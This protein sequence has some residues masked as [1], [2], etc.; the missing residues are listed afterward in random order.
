M[1]KLLS[2]LLAF[3]MIV[4][5]V[6][7][8]FGASDAE[9]QAADNLHVLGLFQGTGTNPDGTPIYSL[10]RAPNRCEAVTMLVRLLGK[11]AEAESGTWGI[12]FT[13]VDSWAVP[14]VGYAYSNQLTFGTGSTTFDGKS[15]VTASQYLT[16]VLR[17]LGY[18]S[19]TD[20]QWNA[21]WELSDRIGLTDGEYSASSAFTRGDAAR[22][23]L[24]AL[25][26]PLKDGSETLAG[27]LIREGV[28]SDA[29]FRTVLF[30]GTPALTAA[31]ETAKPETAAP[32][33]SGV[34][35]VLESEAYE[36][37]L[38]LK[39]QYPEGT[40]WTIRDM[41]HREPIGTGYPTFDAYGCLGFAMLVSDAAFGDIPY[42]R[43]DPGEFDYD[44][45]RVGD[46]LRIKNDTHSV[47]VLEK[48]DTHLI[49]VEGNY[50]DIVHWGRVLSKEEAEK[51]D[52][53]LTRYQDN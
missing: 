39:N 51:A 16:F 4:L 37:I 27:K 20:F 12:P 40:P 41:Y 32:E 22:I 35:D 48:H 42:W 2:V 6:P 47:V 28:F 24:N 19:G 52:Y 21:A 14:Y 30:T 11:E 33:S 3:A 26:I 7:A 23:S 13:D 46:I 50:E 10:D 5:L 1:R 36:R 38:A 25:L 17:A 43:R 29:A 49:L 15:S 53:L 45:I 44:S 8:V 9:I 31:P 34:L 18:E